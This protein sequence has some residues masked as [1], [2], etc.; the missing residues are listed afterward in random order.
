[1]KFLWMDDGYKSN[2]RAVFKLENVKP[3]DTLTVC[4]ADFFRVFLDGKMS[5]YGP[6]RTAA[7]FIRPRTISVSGVKNIEIEV[8]GYNERC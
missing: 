2:E 5:S 6:E 1:M 3:C 4:A 7:G 8:A